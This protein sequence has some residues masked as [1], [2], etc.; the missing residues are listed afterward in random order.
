MDVSSCFK[1]QSGSQIF[2]KT[3][4]KMFEDERKRSRVEGAARVPGM[5]SQREEYPS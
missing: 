3:K 5:F 4:Q 1:I 2:H